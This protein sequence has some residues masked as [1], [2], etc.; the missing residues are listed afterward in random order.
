MLMRQGQI[1]E[2]LQNLDRSR[3]RLTAEELTVLY[4]LAKHPHPQVRSEV[5]AL[6]MDH[7]EEKS[8]A[9]LLS[10]TYDPDSGVRTDAVDSLCIGRKK[11]VLDRLVCLAGNDPASTVRGFAVHSVYDVLLNSYGDS[12][13]TMQ[14]AQTLLAPLLEKEEDAWVRVCYYCVLYLSGDHSYLPDLLDSLD[15]EDYYVRS[16]VLEAF[17]YIIDED[18]ENKIEETLQYYLPFEENENL[19]NKMED[20]LSMIEENKDDHIW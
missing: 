11:P 1:L 18:N 19:M 9:I 13:N 15:D 7:Y 20:L 3:R 6:L 14:T 2:F 17:E 4:E 12:D 5:A 10:L 8:E 16:G